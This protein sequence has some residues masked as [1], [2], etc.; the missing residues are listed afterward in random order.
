MRVLFLFFS[1]GVTLKCMSGKKLKR[2]YKFY[3]Q[4]FYFYIYKYISERHI[5][6][7]DLEQ[8]KII[9]QSDFSIEIATSSN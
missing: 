6:I 3:L 4:F 9:L 5:R 8:N 7:C 2:H 1:K